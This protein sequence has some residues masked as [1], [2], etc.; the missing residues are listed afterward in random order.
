MPATMLP[1]LAAPPTAIATLVAVSLNLK[2]PDGGRA[3]VFLRVAASPA[4]KKNA[5]IWP[6]AFPTRAPEWNMP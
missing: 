6:T 2:A 5:L 4:G 1:M 3:R